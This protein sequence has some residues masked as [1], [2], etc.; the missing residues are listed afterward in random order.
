MSSLRVDHIAIAVHDL[1]SGIAYFE[2]RLGFTLDE[3]RTTQG[4]ATGMRSA[5][6]KRDEVTFV[7]LEG[8]GDRSQVARFLAKHGA[9]VHHVALHATGLSDVVAELESRGL[10]FSTRVVGSPPLRQT[11]TE[12]DDNSAIMI[13]LIERG[14]VTGFD[15]RNV[16]DLFRDLERSDT[17]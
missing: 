16:T 9:G 11:F 14:E 12:R 17:T 13:E 6:L 3:M 15:D 4:E 1:A 7:L 2:D 10:R 5:V 8:D